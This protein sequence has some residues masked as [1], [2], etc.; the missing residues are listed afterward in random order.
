MSAWI[1]AAL[2]VAVSAISAITGVNAGPCTPGS[3]RNCFNT[4]AAIDFSSIPEISKQIVSEEKTGQKQKQPTSEPSAP[5]SYT[6][7]IFG[8]SPRPARTPVI[9]YSWSL[10]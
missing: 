10:E 6:G 7:P 4:P 1:A 5:A 8:A 3:T 9:G 2:A